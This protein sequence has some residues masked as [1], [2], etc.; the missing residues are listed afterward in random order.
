MFSYL[1]PKQ[2]YYR[3]QFLDR[4]AQ[5][6][7]I[8][9][10]F[11]CGRAEG[12]YLFDRSDRPYLDLICGFGVSNLGHCH[13]DIL[14]AIRRQSELYLHTNVYGEHIQSTQVE[15]A[16]L[17]R[18]LLPESLNQVYFLS[19]GS[20]AVDAAIRLAR[21]YTGR[22]GLV[23]MSDAYHGSTI[24][25]ESLRSD[26]E[27]KRPYLPLL[28]D[29]RWIR[30]DQ[31]EDLEKISERTALVITEVVQ[32]EAGVQILN[33]GYLR[34]LRE[35]CDRVGALLAFDEIQTG[36]GRTGSLFAFQQSG[37]VPDILLSG[38]ALGGGLPLAA[39]ISRPEILSSFAHSPAL[40]YIST[41]GGNP[42][43][44]ASG[45]AHL[46]ALTGGQI[47]QGVALRKQIILDQLKSPR[48]QNIR[49]AG[50]LVAAELENSEMVSALVQRA[51]ENQILLEGFLFGRNAFRIAPPLNIDPGVLESACHQINGWLEEL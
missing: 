41:F 1:N 24:G 49:A 11:E 16:G 2:M 35:R 9:Q 20:E 18:S 13:P 50:L 34:A 25:A 37:V 29:V 26:E 33:A 22:T 31:R 32:A 39:L 19:A 47:L 28:P 21:K 15:L 43:C 51:L 5:T 7:E 6:S 17:L 30:A 8:P 38:K 4:I 40:G 12:S 42:L 45:L 36:L 14:A 46:K 48:I 10:A 23:A 27:H 3:Q 44:C